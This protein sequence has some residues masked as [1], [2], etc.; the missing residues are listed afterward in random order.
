MESS[1]DIME[2]LRSGAPKSLRPI[3]GQ[4]A[5]GRMCGVCQTPVGTDEAIGLC[6]LCETLHHVECWRENGG[7]A[8]YGCR[9]MPETIKNAEAQV[10]NTYWGQESKVCPGCHQEV[11]VAALRC[12]HCGQLFADRNPDGKIARVRATQP[13]TRTV[14]WILILA[15]FPA[16]AP[17]SLAWG[18]IFW[19]WRRD[20]LREL[21]QTS[22][23]MLTLGI[24]VGAVCTAALGMAAALHD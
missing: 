21:P 14:N 4:S 2:D 3:D 1:H 20:R 23:V 17:L 16:T 24:M 22:R 8:A 12:R 5:L 10:P 9:A 6:A 19:L 7:C 18:V 13:L 15:I 11:K